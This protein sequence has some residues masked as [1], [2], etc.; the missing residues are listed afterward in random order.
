MS[1]LPQSRPFKRND[2]WQNTPKGYWRVLSPFLRQSLQVSYSSTKTASHMVLHLWA[3]QQTGGFTSLHHLCQLCMSSTKKSS[4][5]DPSKSK[6]NFTSPTFASRVSPLQHGAQQVSSWTVFWDIFSILIVFH[7]EDAG[8]NPF[9]KPLKTH[10]S[11]FATAYTY[12]EQHLW[13][14]FQS[15]ISL[16]SSCESFRGTSKVFTLKTWGFICF[17]CLQEK[18][19]VL[20]MQGHSVT[21]MPVKTPGSASMVADNSWSSCHAIF[22]SL[23]SFKVSMGQVG[24]TDL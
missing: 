5:N 22:T 13:R 20:F 19:E 12:P 18:S 23:A 8:K 4:R 24:P 6:K 7:L 16:G 11:A 9:D 21:E 3:S 1:H 15:D 14:P 2:V 10:F 17:F